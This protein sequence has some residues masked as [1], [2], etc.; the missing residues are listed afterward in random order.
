MLAILLW[1]VDTVI[2]ETAISRKILI[3]EIHIETKPEK[4]TAAC[5]DENVCLEVCK[6]YYT[7]NGWLA[8]KDVVKTIKSNP[9]YYC[10]SCTRVLMMKLKTLYSVIIV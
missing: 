10:G 8:L 9:I 2:V 5:I 1:F 4:L 6:K 3:D 7:R